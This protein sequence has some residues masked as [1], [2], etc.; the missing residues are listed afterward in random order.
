MVGADLILGMEGD[1]GPSNPW[2]KRKR[3]RGAVFAAVPVS[4]CYPYKLLIDPNASVCD[5][6]KDFGFACLSEPAHTGSCG[7]PSLPEQS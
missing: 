2:L 1:E 7:D 6:P 3:L 4:R 5:L